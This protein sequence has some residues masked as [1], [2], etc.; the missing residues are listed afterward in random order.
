M[1][2]R[3]PNAIADNAF[4]LPSS[5]TLYLAED[6]KQERAVNAGLSTSFYI[7]MGSKE[8]QLSM[9]YYYTHFLNSLVVDMDFD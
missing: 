4:I 7:P 8:L 1:G 9:E 2:Y 5:R 3:S 6:I